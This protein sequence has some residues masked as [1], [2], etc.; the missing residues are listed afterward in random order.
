MNLKELKVKLDIAEEVGLDLE[1]I[2]LHLNDS[3]DGQKSFPR[4][5]AHFMH[6]EE[7]KWILAVSYA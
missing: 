5:R 1:T 3:R 4:A 6:D 7:G 2:D